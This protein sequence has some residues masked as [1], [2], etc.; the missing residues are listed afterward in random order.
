MSAVQ[1]IYAKAYSPL[2]PCFP[3][4]FPFLSGGGQTLI[5][6][7][8]GGRDV[9]AQAGT[10]ILF[11]FDM[12]TVIGTAAIMSPPS[13]GLLEASGID[14]ATGTRII[15]LPSL[16]APHKQGVRQ[17]LAGLLTGGQYVATI[18]ARLIDGAIAQCVAPFVAFGTTVTNYLL[19]D[20]IPPRILT[21]DNGF[22]LTVG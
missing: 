13:F 2:V 19:S 5:V 14:V 1:T 22:P 20:D 6:L 17:I 18:R 16:V 4:K 8:A 10:T 11:V 15:G 9:I 7:D 21:D 3:P 12:S